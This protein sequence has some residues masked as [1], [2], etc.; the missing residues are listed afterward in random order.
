MNLNELEL[1]VHLSKS[2]HFARTSRACH[3][4]PSALSRTIQRLEEEVGQSLLERDNRSVALTPAGEAFRL[5]AQKVIEDWKTLQFD[6]A[7]EDS[8]LKG[9]ITL[10]CTVTACYSILPEIL[11]SF[12][13]EYPEVHI[14][15]ETGASA[16]A[17][18]KSAN[19][20][21]DLSIA[22]LPKN[23]PDSI[24]V[25]P[26]TATPL[27]F[28]APDVE[29]AYSQQVDNNSIDW[30][31]V[32]LILSEKGLARKQCDAWFKMQGI[33]PQIYAQV[34]GNEAILAMVA[35]GLG[36]GVVPQLVVDK[37]PLASKVKVLELENPLE[38][39]RVGLCVN[40]KK[41]KNPAT[42]AFWDLVKKGSAT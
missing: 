12:R 35:L 30:S 4:S 41:L 1:F 18:T 22:P 40:R 14:N 36:I 19:G 7:S 5:Y 26:I 24:F 37:S 8:V 38:P 33:E 3:I 17:L 13:A 21:V 11:E 25:H 10:Y 31:T 20:E 15:L 23:I 27:L 6:L 42:Q 9:E 32:P 34:G 39:F 16:S 2:L 28:I 29:W